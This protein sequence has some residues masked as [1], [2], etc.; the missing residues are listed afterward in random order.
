[1]NLE[2]EHR[3]GNIFSARRFVGWYNGIPQDKDIEISLKVKTAIIV[4]Q[5]NVALDC[6]RILL[7]CPKRL[8]VNNT[9]RL[10]DLINLIRLLQTTDITSH[11]SRELSE[12]LVKKV[13]LIG[14]R[15]PFQ[16]AFRIKEFR[17]LT[18][19]D[20]CQVKFDWPESSRK[21]LN[22]DDSIIVSKDRMVFCIL[23]VIQLGFIA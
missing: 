6:A 5:G 12:S 16:G 18:K 19:I 9:S 3:F 17:E 11:A 7:S 8:K 13:I 10:Y 2:N 21:K 23:N 1:M 15:G 20:D 4:G 14:R 22:L